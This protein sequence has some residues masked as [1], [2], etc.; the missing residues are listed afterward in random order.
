MIG[1]DTN[2]LLR[3]V[4]DDDP[5]QSAAV[6]HLLS[7]VGPG[8]ILV[9]LVVIAEFAWVL[10]RGYRERPETILEMVAD[11]LVTREFTVERPDL[12]EAALADARAA[13]CGVADALIG[14]INE[15]RGA[16]ATLTF[17]TRAK[18]LPTMRDAANFP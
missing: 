13:R 17:D 3:L 15:D 18:R 4:L 8:D 12:V 7:N 6:E 16:T 9:G 5:E 10:K 11:L 1:I 14:R 2:V